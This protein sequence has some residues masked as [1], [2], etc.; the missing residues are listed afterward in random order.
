MDNNPI[1]VIG[2]VIKYISESFDFGK[3][4]RSVV[5]T[6]EKDIETID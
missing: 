6:Y 5:I 1:P 2:F 3:Y 4:E